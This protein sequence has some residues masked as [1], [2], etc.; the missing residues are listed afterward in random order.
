MS[1]VHAR[2][3]GSLRRSLNTGYAVVDFETTGMRDNDAIVEI[4]VVLLDRDLS[5]EDTWEALVNPH[6]LI[7]NTDVHGIQEED[8]DRGLTF[9]ALA[10]HLKHLLH[11]RI[12]VA[13]DAT[14]EKRY[15]RYEFERWGMDDTVPDTW[16]DTMQLSSRY[17]GVNK[18]REALAAAELPALKTLDALSDASATANLLRYLHQEH[19]ASVTG[20][21]TAFF[22]G[23]SETE[24]EHT[25]T[26]ATAPAAPTAPRRRSPH[27]P[28]PR[29]SPTVS[30]QRKIISEP[31]T[32]PRPV[33]PTHP[34]V[35]REELFPW[36]ESAPDRAGSADMARVTSAWISQHSHK[37]L[38]AISRYV[39]PSTDITGN[40]SGLDRFVDEWKLQSPDMLSWS[41]QDLLTLEGVGP[42]RQTM[43]VELVVAA[44][45]AE[46]KRQNEEPGLPATSPP[47]EPE[48]S[49]PQPE[50]H[51][52]APAKKTAEVEKKPP[53]VWT[54]QMIMFTLCI[55]FVIFAAPNLAIA[56]L[57]AAVGA[58]CVY[59]AGLKE[60]RELPDRPHNK[61]F[62]P[63]DPNE[64]DRPELIR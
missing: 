18:L 56:F 51:T 14:Y 43:L 48:L 26:R 1:T 7:L 27:S 33:V 5:V 9:P 25:T 2:N 46:H 3:R 58:M 24:P 29:S 39:A 64:E 19:D 53:F 61:Y 16:I 32:V 28:A 44:A 54:A 57:I 47:D 12:L 31:V 20:Y 30:H 8:V 63:I 34:E 35:E 21:P 42:L 10:G 23:R 4:G 50:E 45:T 37:P 62:R 38:F 59:M 6:R 52:P 36:M 40:G 15:L 22:H 55:T 13:H 41:A 49:R 60:G 11:G 17:L